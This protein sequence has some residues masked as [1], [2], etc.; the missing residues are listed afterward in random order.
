MATP[1]PTPRPMIPSTPRPAAPTR[2]QQPQRPDVVAR[3][4]ISG[5]SPQQQNIALGRSLAAQR[6][7]TGA[8]WDALYRLWDRESGW[9]SSEVEPS[10]GA[11]GIPQRHPCNGL[12]SWPASAQIVWGLDYIAGRY[13]TPGAALAHSDATG[14]Y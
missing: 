12:S 2:T 9:D 6:G 14:W 5:G 4:D 8:Q 1:K 3:S 7:W 11:C 10:S 13:G